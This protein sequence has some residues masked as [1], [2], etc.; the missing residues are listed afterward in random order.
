VHPGRRQHDPPAA[1]PGRGSVLRRGVLVRLGRS[2]CARQAQGIIACDFFTVETLWLRT[3][4]VLA[5]IDLHTRRIFLSPATG[6]PP[7]HGSRQQA[8][9]LMLDRE[10]HGQPPR[11]LIHD[12]DTK[13]TDSFTDVFSSEGAELILKLKGAKTPI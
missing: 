1:A 9:N 5:F 2:S 3:M 6:I 13:F 8:R 4:Y 7:R 11:F 12:R 10:P